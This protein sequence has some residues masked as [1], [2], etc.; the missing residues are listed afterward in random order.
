MSEINE[1]PEQ[2][3]AVYRAPALEK[4]VDILELLS[5]EA[6]PLTVSMIVQKLGRST[7]ELF[8][9]I[10]VLERR[11]LI[12]QS[13]DGFVLTPRLFE[14]GVR[15]PQ[16]RDIIET[17]LPV[18]R[19]F[20]GQC[21]QSCHVAIRS[22]SEIVVVARME[23]R[24]LF[25]YSV[26]IGFRCPMHL[27]ASGV[28]LYAFQPDDIR[29]EWDAVLAK[30]MSAAARTEFRKRCAEVKETGLVQQPSTFVS[31]MTDL[32]A[33]LLRGGSAAASLAVPH[34]KY[35]GDPV[36]VDQTRELLIAAAAEISAEL[37]TGDA[38]A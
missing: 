4:G 38:G 37:T 6:R 3:G 9:M 25:G 7:G 13:L 11:G 5:Q 30:S 32:A 23:S 12:S 22:G 35:Q 18:M 2:G 33:P 28:I 16:V 15:R 17:A 27:T 34:L 26:R 10:Q 29:H 36:S 21:G 20:A 14:L 19:R 31:G 24:E 1:E 8:R